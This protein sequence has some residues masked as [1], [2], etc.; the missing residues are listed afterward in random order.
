MTP[1][2]TILAI[3]TIGTLAA[4]ALRAGVDGALFMSAITLIAG[5]GG[6]TIGRKRKQ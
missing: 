6:Y 3:L 2:I 4:L 5:L 1:L